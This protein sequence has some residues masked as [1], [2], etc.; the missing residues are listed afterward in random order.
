MARSDSTNGICSS[1][2][3]AQP[4]IG[5][6]HR[7]GPELSGRRALRGRH[8]DR[9]HPGTTREPQPQARRQSRASTRARGSPCVR[10][11]A[12]HRRRSR[13]RRASSWPPARPPPAAGWSAR[14]ARSSLPPHHDAGGLARRHRALRHELRVLRLGRVG[15]VDHP[16]ARRTP[17]RGAGRRLDPAAPP[18]GGQ[19]APVW[20][21]PVPTPPAR[22]QVPASRSCWTPRRRPGHHG[23]RR[24][25]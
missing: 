6:D 20:R 14:T 15:R 4:S 7:A 21:L 22:R 16:A 12:R 10:S 9:R 11:P 17:R 1:L 19:P 23:A 3:H 5:T 8:P 2:G 18:A 25:R 13:H 24:W